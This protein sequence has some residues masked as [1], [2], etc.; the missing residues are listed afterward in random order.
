MPQQSLC[1]RLTFGAVNICLSFRTIGGQVV[2]DFDLSA[3]SFIADVAIEQAQKQGATALALLPDGQTS[4]YTF[5]NTLKAI[6][7]N[8]KGNLIVAG[9][10]LY[11]SEILQLVGPEAESRLVVAVPWHHLSSSNREF[12]R[13]TEKLWGGEV[14]PRTALSY[15]AVMVLIKAIQKNSH[16]NR[17]NV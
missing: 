17:L 8:R 6:K 5:G 9:D 7:A 15:D 13:S 16:P 14:S 4:A 11:G 10:T 1:F 3:P 12:S 2:K